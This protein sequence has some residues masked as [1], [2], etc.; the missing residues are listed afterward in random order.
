VGK[1]RLIAN[2]KIS[3]VTPSYNQGAYL[4][5]CLRSIL[6]QQYPLLEYFVMDGGSSDGSVDI[7]RRYADRLAYWRSHPDRGHMDA[8]QAG[9]DRSTGEIMGWLNSDD[10]HLPWTLRNVEAI[11][12]LFPDVEW[13]TTRFPLTMDENGIVVGCRRNE[14]FNR[15][16]FTRGRNIP[17]NPRFYSAYIQQEST[18]WRRSLWERAGA[19]LSTSLPLGG[20]F[21]LWNRFF[22]HAK[23]YAVNVPLG[24]FRFQG[25]SFT[26]N[27]MDAYQEA[28][29]QI[30]RGEKARSPSAP[31]C[32]LRRLL[33]LLPPRVYRF[34]PMAY[35]APIIAY[36]GRGGHWTHVQEWFI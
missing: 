13:I 29:A 2:M 25:E 6:D 32:G 31:E 9:F 28:C 4:E 35:P 27:R 26:A 10:M 12:A 15:K 3:L 20:E 8:L 34:L 30:L 16:A 7:I 18:F 19:H 23:L 11:F 24:V 22:K 1:G 21:E 36:T 17:L 33:R 14:G 5:S